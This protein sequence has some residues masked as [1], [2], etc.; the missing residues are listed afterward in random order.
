MTSFPKLGFV[1]EN[2]RVSYSHTAVDDVGGAGKRVVA[3]SH[4]ISQREARGE[5][6]ETHY[7]SLFT[8][9]PRVL[10]RF[11]Y[12]VCSSAASRGY[13]FALRS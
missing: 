1:E 9:G 4:H 2:V 12:R 6:D 5:W 3:G 8:S 10:S 13:F 7:F 11:M